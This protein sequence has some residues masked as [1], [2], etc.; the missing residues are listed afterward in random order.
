VIRHAL[1]LG[2]IAEE[3]LRQTLEEIRS[4]GRLGELSG[5]E[6]AKI[7]EDGLIGWKLMGGGKD[8]A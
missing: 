1:S 5:R 7:A 8:G 6:C 4:R 3:I 2:K